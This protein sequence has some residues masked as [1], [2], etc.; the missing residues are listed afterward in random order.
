MLAVASACVLSACLLEE[1][2]SLFSGGG[3]GEDF[4]NTVQNLGRVTV[5]DVASATQ[6]QQL[7]DLELPEPPDLDGLDSLQ[8]ELP[9]P[10]TGLGKSLMAATVSPPAGGLAK[11]T[12]DTIDLSLWQLDLGGTRIQEAL[13]FG[14]LH[15]YAQQELP[16]LS[17]SDTL[18][19]FIRDRFSV[20]PVSSLLDSI[21]ADPERWL[22]PL[23]V[24]GALIEANG[25]RRTYRLVNS[26]RTETFDEATFTTVTPLPDG[27]TDR[28]RVRIHGPEGAYAEPGAVPEEFEH[29][30][31]AAGGDTLEWTLIRDADWDRRLW[32]ETGS[33]VVELFRIVRGS[34]APTGV[35]RLT[36]NMRA[37]MRRGAGEG[38]DTLLQL[39]L[40]EERHL[41]NGATA[42]FAFEGTGDGALLLAGDTARMQIDTVYFYRDSLVRYGASYRLLLGSAPEKIDEHKLLDFVVARN[43][44]TGPVR[45]TVSAFIPEVPLPIGQAFE[46]MMSTVAA[47]VNGD[48][49]RT[50]GSAGPQGADVTLRKIRAGVEEVWRVLID[51]AGTVLS[52][53]HLD[54]P[55]G[56]SLPE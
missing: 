30:R 4:P 46:G 31:R 48:T 24:R 11:S 41:M 37:G 45:S 29:L 34:S 27:G 54:L 3:G 21:Q 42:S 2:G 9:Q 36:L 43:W 22:M 7:Q 49:I 23:E 13:L 53:E 40:H 26:N 38:G 39:R 33:G 1:G 56:V 35:R 16:G 52:T 47:Y 51:P 8:V 17:R 19:V 18:V 25:S 28:K 15:A 14:R 6:W 55:G 44:R 10:G 12:L 50:E 32:D 20:T 5:T